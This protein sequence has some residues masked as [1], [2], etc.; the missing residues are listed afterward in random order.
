LLLTTNLRNLQ[1]LY[2]AVALKDVISPERQPNQ[3]VAKAPKKTPS[4]VH[5]KK[6]ALKEPYWWAS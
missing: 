5:T 3:K 4:Y 2:T 6:R 1:S